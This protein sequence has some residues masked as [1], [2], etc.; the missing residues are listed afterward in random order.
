M[1]EAYAIKGLYGIE[2][3]TTRDSE[4]E[5]WS[6]WLIESELTREVSEARGYR[7]IPVT[8]NEKGE[9]EALLREASMYLWRSDNQ[10]TIQ[11]AE[12]IDAYLS[13][14]QG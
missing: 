6:D 5:C 3:N 12:R 13:R 10:R 2:A 14:R 11:C 4:A 7:C 8:V 9:A 1:T